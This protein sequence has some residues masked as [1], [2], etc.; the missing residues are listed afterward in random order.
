[1]GEQ[2][3]GDVE[4]GWIPDLHVF[5]EPRVVVQDDPA[6][7]WLVR[8]ASPLPP[9]VPLVTRHIFAWADRAPDRPFLR[10][11]GADGAWRGVTYAE[12]ADR[13]RRIGSA[14]LALGLGPD[15][16]VV[17][18]SGNTVEHA[19]LGLAAQAVGIPYAAV[20]PAYSLADTE[21]GKLR[22][23]LGTLTPG[24]IHV[25]SALPFAAA[26]ALEEAAG[27]AVF[28]TDPT[29]V[30][31]ARVFAELL[32]AP[33]DAG[34]EAVMEAVDPDA[35]AKLLFTSGSTGM[36]KGVIATHRMMAAA[37]EQVAEAWP[38]LRQEPPVLLDWLP[39]NHVF[40]SSKN[41]NMVVR[42][43]GAMWIDDGRPVPGGF[44]QTLANLREVSPTVSFNVPKGYELLIPRLE[45]DPALARAFFARLRIMFYAGAAL[46]PPLWRRLEV[47]AETYGPPGGVHM[48][49]SWG[50]TETAPSI[51]MVHAAR[52]AVG[53]IGTPLPGVE[54][55]LIPDGDKLEA[56]VRGPNVTPGY[57]RDAEATAAAFDERGFFR[58]GDAL[59]WVDPE[60]PAAG[61]I[62]DGRLTEDFKLSTGTRVNSG[63]I[64]IRALAALAPWV[65]DLLVVGEGRQEIG[66][67]L[68]PHH[69]RMAELGTAGL[70][71]SVAAA[72]RPLNE[73]ASSSRLVARALFLREPPSLSAGEITDKGSLNLRAILRRRP[74]E[75]ERLFTDG[76]PEV[77]LP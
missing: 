76:D 29:G 65:R 20:S 53:C 30:A 77:I 54:I 43:G 45:E 47:L 75:L 12:A 5:S 14:L 49:S 32:A 17:V 56:R 70:A 51:S 8:S 74:A 7:G 42:H 61:F 52:A 4:S 38:F 67:L 16:P 35:P 25:D 34:I 11:R 71:A 13:L 46:A 3:S 36:P 24:L 39:W 48:V 58:T 23:I 69:D 6:G 66:L 21:L 55:R 41:L 9:H 50:L 18:L 27:A 64:K 72:L 68:V 62:F 26:L 31:R 60:D 28:A 63:S 15:R 10:Q 22:H 59:R 57:W 19:L 40:G 33:A 1:M 2:V 37:Q 44:E 73:G